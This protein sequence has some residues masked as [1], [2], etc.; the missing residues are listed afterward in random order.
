[1]I[2]AIDTISLI[3]LRDR[4]LIG[5]MVYTFARRARNEGL[6]LFRPGA[7]RLGPPP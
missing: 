6:G 3:S 1:M 7:A 2:A 4:T 5:I